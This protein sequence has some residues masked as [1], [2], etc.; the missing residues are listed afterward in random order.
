LGGKAIIV[1]DESGNYVE[2]KY[3]DLE[4]NLLSWPAV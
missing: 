4:G 3:F 1:R 2:T